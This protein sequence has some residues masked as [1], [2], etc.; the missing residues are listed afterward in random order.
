MPDI[1]LVST[2]AES[3]TEFDREEPVD[4]A[5]LLA[6]EI[7]FGYGDGTVVDCEDLVV[8]AGEVTALVGPNGSGKSTLLKGLS[9]ELDPAAGIVLL[10]GRAVQE[11]SPKELARELG[12]L[13]Q[14]NDAP[15]GLTVADLVTHGRYPHRGFL[16]PITDADRAAIDRAIDLAGV[17][18]LRDTPLSRLSGGQKQLAFVAMT[19]AQDTDVLLLDEPTTYLDL[20]HQLRVMEVVRTLNEER[21]VTV[22]VVLHDLQQAARFA[23]Y[24]VALHNGSVYDWGPPQDVVTERL[25]ADV[26]DVDA[27]VSYDDEPRIVPRR[28]ID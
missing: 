2:G 25:L 14:E 16:D 1:P 22:C 18:H 8:P 13:D 9:A 5:A 28:A 27:A 4:D 10:N 12:L 7:E 23:D 17:D 21:D 24:L 3:T 15:G 11:R 20:H 19:L 26:F 6:S